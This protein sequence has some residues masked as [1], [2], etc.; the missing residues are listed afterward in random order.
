VKTLAILNPSLNNRR[1]IQNLF[2]TPSTAIGDPGAG[3]ARFWMCVRLCGRGGR[4][5][6]KEGNMANRLLALAV[7]LAMMAGTAAAQDAKAVLQAAAKNMGADNL[8][9]IE[10]SGT[11]MNAAVGQSYSPG[12]DWPRF[13]VTSYTKTIDYQ[14]RSSREQITRRQGNYPPQGGG[15]T[16]IQ[17]EQQQH[18][19]SSGNYAWNMDGANANPAPAAAELRQLEILLTPHGFLKAAM[20]SNPTAYTRMGQVPGQA[21]TRV[22]VISFTALGKYKVSGAI[23]DQNLVEHVQTWVANPVLGDM[24]Y[25]I[26]YTQYKDFGAVKFP[27][28]IHAHQGDQRLD[29]GHNSLQITVKNVRPNVTVPAITVPENVRKFTPAAIRVDA[30]KL[31]DGVWYLGGAGANS[32][33]VEFRDFVAVVE[34]PTNEERS[35]AVI[36]EVRRLIP[37]KPIRYLVNT[38]HHFDHAGGMRTYVAEG[39]TIITHERNRDFY[40]RVFFAPA[41]RTLQ[42]DR[43]ALYPRAPL[44]ETLNQRYALSDGTRIME[45]YYVPGLAHNQNMLIAYLPKE[46]IVVEGDLYTPPAAGAPAPTPNASNRTFYNV[47][48]QL[49]LEISQIA[50][51]HGRV[52]Q[53]DEFAKFVGK[54]SN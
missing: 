15:G 14:N 52:A 48:Q 46:K 53:W 10:I 29:E 13:E 40:E 32:V 21:G 45:I 23:N 35:I 18:F 19:V 31:A 51:I 27:T 20:T 5:A 16:P 37:N 3:E 6:G 4:R 36:N 24:L 33:L 50:S 17:G 1:N 39:A 26:R 47:I 9:T 11:G 25:E 49:R 30:Q 42:S 7:L 43:L 38:H 34:A 22:T 44:F 28:D 54:Q 12:T 41:P 2:I 8:R